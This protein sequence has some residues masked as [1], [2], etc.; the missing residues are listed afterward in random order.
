MRNWLYPVYCI[1]HRVLNFLT[2]SSHNIRNTNIYPHVH[3]FTSNSRTKNLVEFCVVYVFMLSCSM[4][5]KHNIFSNY[6][7]NRKMQV[8]I[9]PRN[10]TTGNCLSR[11]CKFIFSSCSSFLLPSNLP[12]SMLSIQQKNNSRFFKDL[13]VFYKA[14]TVNSIA[15]II[16]IISSSLLILYKI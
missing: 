7:K 11:G 13:L 10:W 6:T 3:S 4:R 12:S 8:I 15:I 14:I 9:F 2:F 1:L 16:I 5:L